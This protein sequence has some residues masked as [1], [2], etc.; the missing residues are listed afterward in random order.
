MANGQGFGKQICVSLCVVFLVVLFCA[1]RAQGQAETA[2]ITGTATDPS[3]GAIVGAKVEATNVGTNA[4]QNTVTDSAGRYKL[5]DLSV[6]TYSVQASNAGFKVVVHPGVV[7]SVGGTVVV[8]FALPVGQITQTVN[9]ESDVSR[10]E[11]TTSDVSTLVSP[12]QMRNLPLNGRNFEQLI[13][14]APGVSTVPPALNNFVVGRLY[15]AQDNYSISGSRPTG[16]MFLLD[17]TD[18]RDFWEHGT[19]SGYGGTSL[20]VEAIGEFQ[21][22]T[23]TYSAQFGGAGAAMNAVSRAGTNDLH[24]TVYEFFR[25][26]ALDARDILD[27]S[28][29]P[30][31]FKRNQFGGDLGGAIKK[32]KLFFFTNYEGLR[33]GLESTTP[34]NLPEPYLLNSELPCGQPGQPVFAPIFPGGPLGPNTNN[35]TSA[36]CDT[37]AG[38]AHA[39]NPNAVWPGVSGVATGGNPIEPVTGVS[40][41]ILDIT[42]VYQ[43]CKDCRTAS[44]TDQG[45]FF[46][47]TTAP[48][49]IINEDY[50]LGRLDYV[51]GTN[52]S[53]F[54]RFVFD[55]TRVDD[56]PRD[57]LGI[58]P[59][60]DFTRNQFLTITERHVFSPTIVN[61]V[62][63]G[64]TRNNE[65]SIVQEHLTSAQESAVGLNYDPLYFNSVANGFTDGAT[66]EDGQ[67]SAGYATAL[68]PS[69]GPD[70]NRPDQIVQSKFSG[71]DDV[72]WSHGAHS[73]K[74]G[75]IVTRV[76]TNNEQ[77][78]YGNG[79]LYFA[80][81]T[82]TD[83][84]QG[85]FG[86]GFGVP[87]TFANSTRYFRET[88]VAPYIQDDW[89]I[90]SRLTINLGIRYDYTTNPVGWALG[91]GP[92][93]SITGSFLPPIGP[94]TPPTFVPGEPGTL[95][96]PVKHV[97]AHNPN[98][99]NF[100]PRLGLAW[101]PFADHKTSIRAGF[102]L[103]HDPVAARIY[104]SG[105]IATPPALSILVIAPGFPNF[106][107][108][109][110]T[111]PGEFAGVDYQVPNGSPYGMQYNVNI[112]R[113]IAHSTVLS[114]GYI[115]STWRH[116]W[117]QF[118]TNIPKCDTYPDCTAIPSR[119]APNTGAHFTGPGFP[120]T[121]PRLNANL[122]STVI[123]NTTAAS[124]Y[125]S[126]QVSL[127]R[128]FAHNLSGQVNYTYSHSIDDGSF[129]TSLEE[130]TPLLL[131]SYNPRYDYGNS[132][133]D[134]RH[135]L[136][137]NGLYELPFRGNRL[138]EGWQFATILGVHSGQPLDVAY[139]G[140]SALDPTYLGS[141]W[142]SRPNYS[143][144]PGCHPNNV[145]DKVTTFNGVTGLYWFDPNCYVAQ[146][147]GFFGDVTR[148]SLPGPGALSLDFSIIKN[149]KITERLNMQFRAEAFNIINHFNPGAP[150]TTVG[151]T[152]NFGFGITAVSQ[153]P[154]ITPRQIQFAVKFDF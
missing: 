68:I 14:L 1:L 8:D 81:T 114:V 122:G 84:L 18:I 108:G 22:L 135:N 129:A 73:I 111:P 139:G 143:G 147:P 28:S 112:Q 16:Q 63:F 117:Q 20:G 32:D 4:A 85:I 126:I 10:V 79:T 47:A 9:V 140:N 89:K 11:T 105:F 57:P 24:G 33:Q 78:A 88:D 118:D 149:T 15:G 75:A 53:L 87:D 121:P 132:T 17:N 146:T 13:T 29:G 100:A 107:T 48:N 128:Q 45:G 50:V 3:G 41:Q 134:I 27:P 142:G 150:N 77:Q 90:T 99:A 60:K 152:G 115:G 7:L 144:A 124:S 97:F 52:D 70:Q 38:N 69:V 86:A 154:V 94:L 54:G 37:L 145:I 109:F 56:N 92:L 153:S 2:S 137:V 55:D 103:Y 43:L 96:T 104:E 82:Q 110:Q 19:G 35:T 25:N 138:V 59:E 120:F 39:G 95:F 136:S 49:L 151:T 66:R 93:S 133:F 127:N 23:N 83:Y 76:Q 46:A 6:G 74:I 42:K 36:T 141:Q 21:L 65:H 71:G 72:I 12:E 61:S 51:L 64:Y 131:D 62:R 116:L 130:F 119:N 113:E 123:E 91:G 31:P 67:V 40:Q 125:N 58:F 98:S 5:S 80:G 44:T 34:V 148:N 26:S 106:T 101:D 30:P 102:G